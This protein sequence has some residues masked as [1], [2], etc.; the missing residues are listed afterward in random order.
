VSVTISIGGAFAPQ[1]VRSSAP[2]WIERA[3][4]QL[5]RAKS[6]GR[7][8]ACLEQPT[9]SLVSAAEKSLLFSPSQF[10]DLE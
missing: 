2:L 7:N 5:Y 6:E 8:R 10:Q 1:W 9:V 4:Q 3:D